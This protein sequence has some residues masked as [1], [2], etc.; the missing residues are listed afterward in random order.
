MMIL[1]NPAYPVAEK[2]AEHRE[3]VRSYLEASG[4][5]CLSA[6]DIRS[7]LPEIAGDLPNVVLAE[8]ARA[9][10]AAVE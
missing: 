8:I 7:G 10:G 9:I 6:D 4:C 2:A 5:A 3:A 1:R